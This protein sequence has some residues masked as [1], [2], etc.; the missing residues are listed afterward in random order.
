MFQKVE[1][2]YLEIE[3]GFWGIVTQKGDKFFPINLP[4]QL[5][6]NG[7][8]AYC[9]MEPATDVMTMQMWGTPVHITSFYTL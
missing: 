6:S 5:K 9:I 1:I 7:S 3:G 2:K 4:E 8:S